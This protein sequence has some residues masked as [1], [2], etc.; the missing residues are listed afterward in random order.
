MSVVEKLDALRA[1]APGC[2]LAAFGDLRTRLVLR[3]SA[4]RPWPQE[5]L[6]ELCVQAARCFAAA[7]SAAVTG[8]FGAGAR[9]DEAVLLDGRELRLFLRSPAD[10]SDLVCVVCRSVDDFDRLAG[11]ARQMVGSL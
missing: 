5:R 6:D 9:L 11:L 8:H 3:A 4:A 2:S 1:A 7:D 10:E